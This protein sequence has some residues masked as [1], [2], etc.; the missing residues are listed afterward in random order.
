[1]REPRGG[2][3]PKHLGGS[4]VPVAMYRRKT[5]MKDSTRNALGLV[6]GALLFS[7]SAIAAF[8][9][10]KLDRVHSKVAFTAATLIFD[11]DG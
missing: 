4:D 2:G 11:V 5:V 10:L 9:P 1:M 7:S 6:F 3:W 8:S